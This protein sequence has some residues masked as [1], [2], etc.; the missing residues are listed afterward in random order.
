LLGPVGG[1]F[2]EDCW[3]VALLAESGTVDVAG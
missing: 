3:T 1:G 2:G